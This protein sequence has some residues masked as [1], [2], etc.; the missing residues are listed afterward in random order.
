MNEDKRPDPKPRRYPRLWQYFTLYD[1]LVEQRKKHL[2]RISSAEKGK[3]FCF[4]LDV[5]MQ[6]LEDLNL[7][8][9]IKAVEKKMIA[10]GKE[11]GFIWEWLT[12]IRGL[13]SGSLAARLAAMIDDPGKFDTVSKL[14]RFSGLAVIDGKAEVGTQHYNRRL[15]SLLLGP[16][17]IVDQF[18]LK[19]TDVYRGIYDREKERLYREH[20]DPLC[21]KC[22]AV[23]VKK[24][25]S[26]VCPE[27]CKVA[28]GFKVRY[29]PIH[30]DKMARR[31]VAHVFL[32]HV[33]VVWRE[34]E[35][36]PLTVPW[37]F[38]EPTK[39]SHYIEPPPYCFEVPV[40][41]E[42]EIDAL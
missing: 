2:L 5:E 37:I 35:G 3:T 11:C 8:A 15:K 41:D 25:K 17:F 39:H 38:R 24:G 20:P 29:T 16:N 34:Q 18:V 4:D 33:W 1:E 21:N 32:Q 30:I 12:S 26:W 36:L 31:K 40:Y 10:A 13:G 42:A 6:F 27:G 19:R 14:W 22:D 28:V 7:D 9:N 23:A